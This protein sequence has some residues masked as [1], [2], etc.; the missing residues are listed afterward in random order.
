MAS[1]IYRPLNPERAEIRLLQLHPGSRDDALRGTLC[2]AFLDDNTPPVY[3]TISYCWGD[4]SETAWI[5]V[6]DSRLE[7]AKSTAAALRRIRHQAEPRL[8]WIDGVCINQKDVLEKNKQVPLMT[9]VYA[10]SKCNLAILDGRPAMINE[11]VKAIRS[12]E[13]DSRQDAHH[14]SRGSRT[15]SPT[16]RLFDSEEAVA[17]LVELYTQALFR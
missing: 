14:V 8:L 5:T 15:D 10:N 9:E 11:A 7:V 12:V 16:L 6:N 13:A 3:E 1:S 4:M 2:H 17:A